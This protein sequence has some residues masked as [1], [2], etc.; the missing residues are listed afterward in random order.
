MVAPF[1][2]FMP[3]IA[4]MLIAASP[5]A[6]AEVIY[7]E[8]FSVG[9]SGTSQPLTYNGWNAHRATGGAQIGSTGDLAAVQREDS[10][11]PDGG[12]AVNSNPV[13]SEGLT[14]RVQMDLLQGTATP[15]D[16][17]VWTAEFTIDRDVWDVTALQ[18]YSQ[19]TA[20]VDHMHAVVRIA[21]AWY[22][23]DAYQTHDAGSQTWELNSLSF[24]GT[25]WIPLSFTPGTQLESPI[26]G[27]AQTL[28]D[29]QIG[30]FGL[31]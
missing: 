2:M 25:D 20:G 6:W 12:P 1:R 23:S 22:V 30:A 19:H 24:A 18:W 9:Q 21:G 27:T 14:G 8:K 7:R 28:P 29:G 4:V 17:I 16:A 5:S 26:S 31:Y 15:V 3:V 13:D 10:D 11:A